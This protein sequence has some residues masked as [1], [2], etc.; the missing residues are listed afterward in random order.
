MKFKWGVIF[1]NQTRS[2]HIFKLFIVSLI[3]TSD[4]IMAYPLI[5]SLNMLKTYFLW[6]TSNYF[7][8]YFIKGGLPKALTRELANFYA[9]PLPT[10]AQ[11]LQTVSNA[12]VRSHCNF[13]T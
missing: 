7:I 1:N 9:R 2:L 5:N 13:A 11:N 4:N 12:P 6:E 10:L 8:S 3:T